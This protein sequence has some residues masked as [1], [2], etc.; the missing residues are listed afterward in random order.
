MSNYNYAPGAIHND[1]HQ[2]IN[3]NINLDKQ[4]RKNESDVSASENTEPALRKK[5]LFLDANGY[6][7]ISR[8]DEE[9]ARVLRYISEHKYGNKELDGSS[10][11]PLNKMAVA[12]VLRWKEKKLIQNFSPTALVRF[13]KDDCGLTCSVDDKT[14]A[15][16]LGRM[17]KRN[18][19]NDVY[20]DVCDYFN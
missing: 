4:E 13:L 11:N 7:D 17:V 14:L 19:K 2:E 15:N 10:E 8:R 1:Y 3:W 5:F 18:E 9:K 16:L 12:F 6:E 20:Y